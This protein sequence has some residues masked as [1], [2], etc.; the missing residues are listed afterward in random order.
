[1]LNVIVVI[2]KLTLEEIEA[3]GC[4]SYFTNSVLRKTKCGLQ[5]NF[6]NVLGP[7]PC[8]KQCENTNV[9]ETTACKAKCDKNHNTHVMVVCPKELIRKTGKRTDKSLIPTVRIPGH[10]I[11]ELIYVELCAIIMM[12][13]LLLFL[14]IYRRK[15][16][17]AKLKKFVQRVKTLFQHNKANAACIPRGV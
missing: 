9:I 4:K 7:A 12:T 15:R 17:F 8:K 11:D 14:V 16:L 3:R 6:E 5:Y 10:Y 2:C 13:V 1:M